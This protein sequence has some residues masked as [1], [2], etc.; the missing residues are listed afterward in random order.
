MRYARPSQRPERFTLNPWS[1]LYGA[2]LL[3]LGPNQRGPAKTTIYEDSSLRDNQGML[4][5]YTGAGNT[6]AD[7]WQWDNLLRRWCVGANGSS[8]YILSPSLFSSASCATISA[9]IRMRG[10]N[11]LATVLAKSASGADFDLLVDGNERLFHWYFSTSDGNQSAASTTTPVLGTW[12]HVMVT[13]H[14]GEKARVIVNGIV[15]NSVAQNHAWI[16]N[17]SQ[18][19]IGMSY[20][21]SSRW[22]NADVAD[23]LVASFDYAQFAPYLA[24][25]SNYDLRVGNVPLLLSVRRF[26]GTGL[27]RAGP[28]RRHKLL[29]CLGGD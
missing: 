3:G 17:A 15:E 13:L 21:R 29:A 24:D 12:Y 14:A 20:T 6:P 27:H 16:G 18:F 22:A 2:A 5:G 10:W 1:P 7:K 11:S 9:W 25:P 8:D 19:S 4:Y 23:V 28:V 26:W